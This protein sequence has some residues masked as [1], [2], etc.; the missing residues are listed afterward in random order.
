[1]STEDA[2]TAEGTSPD[3]D[4]KEENNEMEKLGFTRAVLLAVPLFC[5]FI[6]VL[7]IKFLTDLVVFP[8]LILY[9]LARLTKRRV[10]AI[11]GKGDKNAK[12]K[13]KKEPREEAI[14]I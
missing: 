4:S 2:D 1:M 12:K 14:D 7:L 13:A 5:K 8:L 11:F 6:I 9:R 3:S 10:L